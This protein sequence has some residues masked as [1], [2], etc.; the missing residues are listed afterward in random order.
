M[1]RRSDDKDDDGRTLPCAVNVRNNMRETMKMKIA[2][3]RLHLLADKGFG[4]LVLHLVNE[5]LSGK[6]SRLDYL[7]TPAP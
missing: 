3:K 6:A 1:R 5:L 4:I 2:K 7:L